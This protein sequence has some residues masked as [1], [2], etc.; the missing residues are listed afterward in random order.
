MRKPDA[1][2]EPSDSEIKDELRRRLQDS[3]SVIDLADEITQLLKAR[4]KKPGT[5]EEVAVAVANKV[6]T[7]FAK[8]N[9]ELDRLIE[10]RPRKLHALLGEVLWEDVQRLFR[11]NPEF[12]RLKKSRA[13]VTTDEERVRRAKASKNRY[14][15]RRRRF[16]S[17][18][19][20]E[21]QFGEKSPWSLA[22][23]LDNSPPNGP[24]LDEIFHGGTIKMC[25]DISSLQLLF[26]LT[27]KKLYAAGPAIRRGRETF[28]DYRAVVACMDML[29][30]QK[31]PDAN[32][33]PDSE[34]RRTVL[35]GIFFRAQQEATP[36]IREA[37]GKTLL[38]HLN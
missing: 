21:Q 25:D 34:R 23:L 30:T 33:L 9:R 38:P 11:E 7:K 12:F 2:A 37:F 20:I 19:M 4:G 27:R 28:Y 36:E 22:G 10:Y 1:M 31:G 24:C 15:H 26:G 32:W 17:L 8:S 18:G 6:V 3:V 5:P 14:E 35:T 13:K 29:L 16:I